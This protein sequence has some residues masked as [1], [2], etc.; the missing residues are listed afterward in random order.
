[1]KLLATS[2]KENSWTQPIVARHV[3]GTPA[4]DLEIVDGFHRW[5]L[6]GKDDG[7]AALSAGIRPGEN[8]S[9]REAE[10]TAALLDVLDVLDS[11]Q[12]VGDV[13]MSEDETTKVK[14]ARALLTRYDD[15]DA[16]GLGEI[17]VPVVELVGADTATLMM[18]TVR[19]NRARGAHHVTRMADIVA[20]LVGEGLA[21]KEISVR[22][23]MDLIEV[24]RLK[25]RGKMT[26]RA[27]SEDGE[28]SKAWHA[29]LKEDPAP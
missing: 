9:A 10:L 3:D 5:T 11:Q 6:T 29:E 4:D 15:E 19:H 20:E 2:L 27:T 26:V 13:P 22:L 12:C 25:T 14:G 8:V 23:G 21:D 7:V 17:L 16:A 1:M 18:A 28:L 24:E